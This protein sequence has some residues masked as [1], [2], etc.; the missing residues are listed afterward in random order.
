MRL[1]TLLTI[2]A[3]A[4]LGSTLSAAAETS[5]EVWKSPTCGCCEK[6]VSHLEENGFAVKANDTDTGSLETIKRA[7]GISEKLDACHTGKIGGYVIEGHVPASDVKRLIESEPS[8]EEVDDFLAK[9]DN[10][11]THPLVMH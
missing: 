2:T 3:I 1:R 8:V 4:F 7:S 9:F 5:I 6:W 10:V 11:M